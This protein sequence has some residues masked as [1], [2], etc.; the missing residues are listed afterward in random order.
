MDA[1]TDAGIPSPRL[2]I[3][4][5]EN[6]AGTVV[7]VRIRDNGLGIAP[8]KQAQLFTP[9]V[10]GKS[11][12]T[13]LGLAITKKLVEAHAGS[14]EVSNGGDPGAEFLLSFPKDRSK[15]GLNDGPRGGSGRSGR[16][17]WGGRS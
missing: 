4:M 17:E 7:W 15:D 10:T 16:D 8:E 6:L 13:G 14:I 5:G 1:L 9:F 2:D 11:N 12:G 3:S